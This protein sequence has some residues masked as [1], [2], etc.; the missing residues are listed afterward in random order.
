MTVRSCCFATVLCVSSACATHAQ[1]AIDRWVV[2]GGGGSSTGAD[3]ELSGTAG[4]HAAGTTLSGG[5]FAVSGGYWTMGATPGP[6]ICRGDLNCDGFIDF[7]DINEFVLALSNWPA[8]QAKF[9]DCPPQNADV[10]GDGIYG[11]ANGFNDINP[12]VALLSSGGGNPIP[13][14]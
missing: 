13:C 8:W 11:G 1:L 6:T 12:F 5:D 9:P 14:P 2:A 3:F 4:Q 7:N 10:N